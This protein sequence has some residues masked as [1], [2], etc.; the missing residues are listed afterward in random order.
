M[1]PCIGYRLLF[2]EGARLTDAPMI[3]LKIGAVLALVTNWSLFQTL[4]FDL[5]ERAPDGNRGR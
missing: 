3:A 1:S 2:G 4:V 5:A